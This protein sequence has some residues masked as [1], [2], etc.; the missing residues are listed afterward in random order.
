MARGAHVIITS[1]EGKDQ[2]SWLLPA[3][4]SDELMEMRR[5][6]NSC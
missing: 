6:E 3:D 2:K 4:V 1:Y 5:Y